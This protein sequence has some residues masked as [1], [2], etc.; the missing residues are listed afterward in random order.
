MSDNSEW[1]C[2]LYLFQSY[3]ESLLVSHLVDDHAKIP[4]E[5]WQ[6]LANLTIFYTAATMSTLHQ[7]SNIKLDSVPTASS[8]AFTTATCAICPPSR[9][10]G[11]AAS[12]T[13]EEES[14]RVAV[15]CNDG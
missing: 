2:G 14:K 7:A 1:F 5:Q 10:F 13:R 15:G 4:G 6:E 9:V 3:D 8:S 12:A 11:D